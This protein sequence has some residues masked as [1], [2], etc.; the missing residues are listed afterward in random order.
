M[1]F[2]AFVGIRVAFGAV[3]GDRCSD[4]HY[5]RE[6]AS[7]RHTDAGP[8]LSDHRHPLESP[9]KSWRVAH[10]AHAQ[11]TTVFGMRSV[12]NSADAV[13]RRRR[14][15]CRLFGSWLAWES[16]THWTLA[17]SPVIGDPARRARRRGTPALGAGLRPRRT[18]RPMVASRIGRPA[19]GGVPRS[20]DRPQ[21]WIAVVGRVAR[22]GD[23]P[24]RVST[25]ARSGDRPQRP[26]WP[27]AARR[28]RRSCNSAASRSRGS[29]RR[30]TR[31]RCCRR[32]W[33]SGWPAAS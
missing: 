5:D 25:I 14:M 11:E 27:E 20:G 18:R 12:S 3:L 23:R 15:A 4:S 6:T 10:A 22:S 30:P 24:Q 16:R 29:D 26:H 21:R 19:V 9:N 32:G 2:S 13:S 8:S 17:V 1:P 28:S 31:G 7:V 33:T